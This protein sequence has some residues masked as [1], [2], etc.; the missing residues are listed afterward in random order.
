MIRAR[1]W[2]AGIFLLCGC[3][4]PEISRVREIGN[5]GYFVT[6]ASVPEAN[7]ARERLLSRASQKAADFC[8]R[9]ARVARLRDLM[10]GK[11]NEDTI[12]AFDC[13]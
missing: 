9:Q 3:H 6:I 7:G 1:A 5:G 4:T 2:Y 13:R 12:I 10:V 8:A 11:K